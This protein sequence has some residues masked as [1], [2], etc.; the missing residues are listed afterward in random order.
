MGGS[1]SKQA[2]ILRECQEGVSGFLYVNMKWLVR[3]LILLLETDWNSMNYS[4]LMNVM[5]EV[6]FSLL[7]WQVGCHNVRCEERLERIPRWRCGFW[8]KHKRIGFS[9]L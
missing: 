2:H 6:S 1:D 4:K 8:E 9:L 3:S 7:E 5:V